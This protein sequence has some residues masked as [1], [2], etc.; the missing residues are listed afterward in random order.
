MASKPRTATAGQ[1]LHRDSD[2]NALPVDVHTDVWRLLREHIEARM[3]SLAAIVLNPT[4]PDDKRRDYVAR[5]DELQ[6]LLN[7]PSETLRRAT[8]RT[9][10][11][12]STY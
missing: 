8:L 5:R 10:S 9:D 7:A 6:R 2:F 1:T 11:P 12:T 3:E 4:T